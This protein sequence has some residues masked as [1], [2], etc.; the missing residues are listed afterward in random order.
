VVGTSVWFN[1]VL[2]R[3]ES[4][5]AA[6]PRLADNDPSL[7]RVVSKRPDLT[8][9]QYEWHVGPQGSV[10]T[11]DMF[12][13]LGIATYI[14]PTDCM[15]KDNSV[16]VDGT[17]NAMYD[18]AVLYKGIRELARVH[19][20]SDAGEKLVGRL[21]SREAAAIEKAK[22][23]DLAG[24]S[25]VFWF[26]SAQIKAD[27]YVAGRKGVPGYMMERLGIDNVVQSDEEWPTV[28]WETI[29]QADPDL[30]V[31]AD[32][33]RRRFPADDAAKKREFLRTDPVV[34]QLD[35]V[36]NDRILVMDAHAMDPS[37]RNVAA[38]ERL[39]DELEALELSQQ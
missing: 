24:V 8:A 15:N 21:R 36:K 35:A 34:R 7:E 1:K 28:G 5:N 10:G 27:P 25:A 23:L 13:D 4:V 39:A 16:G 26:S 31:V 32:M 33:E 22:A 3:F 11:R 18:T 38:L 14:L 37:I 9:A 19:D 29:V 12:H 20:V 30:I 6:I 2:P 17:R